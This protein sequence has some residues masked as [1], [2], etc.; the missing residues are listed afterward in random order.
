[1]K[2]SGDTTNGY[3]LYTE[4]SNAKITN[5]HFGSLAI[6]VNQE[7]GTQNIYIGNEFYNNADVGFYSSSN[8]Y[9]TVNDNICN[10][11][12]RSGVNDASIRIDGGS[13]VTINSNLIYNGAGHGILSYCDSSTI[14]G[15]V[16]YACD[17]NSANNYA[18]IKQI[19][20]DKT[21]IV[22]NC[23]NNCNNAGAGTTY[24]IYINN[25]CDEITTVG[26]TAL[27]NDTNLSD[28]GTNG[29]TASNNTA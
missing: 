20:G 16:I 14:V 7:I 12:G 2:I 5:S 24:G 11:N 27:G 19:D 8:S 25:T 26:N 15:N 13:A 21:V 23:I 18:G 6:G 28:N 29:T 3:G 17:S 10:S 22:G 9:L 1:M 4:G